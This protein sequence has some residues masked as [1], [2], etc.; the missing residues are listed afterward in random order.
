MGKELK[1]EAQVR[2]EEKN[3]DVKKA[4]FIPAVI[5]GSGKEATSLKVKLQDFKKVFAV[6]GESTLINLVIDGKE[7][8]KVIVKTVQKD[9]IKNEFVH[10]DFYAIDMTK[11]IQVE[12]PLNFVGESKAV[13]ELG[14]TLLQTMETVHVQCLPG[15][16]VE[17]L[18]VDL[19]ILEDFS[20]SIRVSDVQ[21]PATI[22]VIT[23]AEQTVAT[24]D[25][26]RS[27]RQGAGASGEEGEDEGTTEANEEKKE[28][29]AEEA[30]T[31]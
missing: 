16:L 5:Y 11:K 25:M 12:I 10:V 6:A 9:A 19:G 13:K 18:D 29:G 8:V 23:P 26:P 28:E 27:A 7:P 17:S 22:E 20:T 1:L 21:A 30:K 24:V 31:E 2:A 3:K 14:G 15:D 4:G